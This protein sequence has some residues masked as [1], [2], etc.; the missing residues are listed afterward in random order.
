MDVL[1]SPDGFLKEV[2]AKYMTP[3]NCAELDLKNEFL[4]RGKVHLPTHIYH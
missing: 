3:S 1:V 2:S 4:S